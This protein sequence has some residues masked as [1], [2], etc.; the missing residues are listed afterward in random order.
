V[1]FPSG[2]WI[3]MSEGR[4]EQKSPKQLSQLK[5]SRVKKYTPSGFQFR[6]SSSVLSIPSGMNTRT[7]DRDA[8]LP[9]RSRPG[10]VE[11]YRY[12]MPYRWLAYGT[13]GL[14]VL[15]VVA[16]GWVGVTGGLSEVNWGAYAGVGTALVCAA[17]SVPILLAELYLTEDRLQ[18][19]SPLRAE[20]EVPLD[21][22]RRVFIGGASVELYVSS[23]ADPALTFHRKIQGSDD[24]IVKLVGCLPASATVD[25]PSGEMSDRLAERLTG[26]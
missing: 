1:P 7:G 18:K 6:R 5:H 13:G 19:T 4:G 24:L 2:K 22:V 3:E 8:E 17:T 26:T 11:V 9:D 14:V 21:E 12:G 25:H 15:A 10:D 20:R 16:V 23:D